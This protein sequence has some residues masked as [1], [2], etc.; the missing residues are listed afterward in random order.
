MTIPNPLCCFFTLQTGTP[1][2]EVPFPS[3]II[4]SEGYNLE[5]FWSAFWKV[6]FDRLLEGQYLSEINITPIRML[7]YTNS[8][9]TMVKNLQSGYY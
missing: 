9:R 6:T 2:A 8:N 3:V 5:N 7:K 1:V 4:C